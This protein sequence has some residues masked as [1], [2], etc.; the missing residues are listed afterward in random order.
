LLSIIHLSVAMV[1]SATRMLLLTLAAA[2]S[3]G[4]LRRKSES[5]KTNDTAATSEP[6]ESDWCCKRAGDFWDTSPGGFRESRCWVKK[7]TFLD[8]HCCI[9]EWEKNGWGLPGKHIIWTQPRTGSY[10]KNFNCD[11][12]EVFRGGDNM[13]GWIL[14]HNN[15]GDYWGPMWEKRCSGYNPIWPYP[16]NP[17]YGNNPNHSKTMN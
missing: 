7:P 16:G 1:A 12:D 11:R 6:K 15:G 14:W 4:A 2:S 3:A 5:S 17:G 9:M 13:C 10:A 8:K